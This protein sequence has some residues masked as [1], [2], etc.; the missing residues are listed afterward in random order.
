M[1]KADLKKYDLDIS[2]RIARLSD[3]KRA[4]LEARLQEI[5]SKRDIRI[6]KRHGDQETAPLSFAQERLWFLSQLEPES[7]FYNE[8]GAIE[9]IGK[10]NNYALEQSLREIVRR[11]EILRTT[12]VAYEGHP[13]QRIAP[14]SEIEIRYED[15]Q[16]LPAHQQAHAIKQYMSE[17]VKRPFNLNIGPLIRFALIRL[18]GE[19]HILLV[20]LHHIIADE[21]SIRILLNE[22]GAAYGAFCIGQP[23]P[24]SEL[25][26]QYA[27]YACWQ[28]EW[29]KGPIFN[30][31]IAYWT[32]QLKHSPALL[33]LPTDFPR[34]SVSRHVG[35]RYYFEISQETTI[36]L[37]Q[38]AKNH[39]ATLFMV[40][41]ASF[42]IL[43]NRYTHQQ[44]ICIG[45]P[46]ANRARIG[47]QALIGFFANTLVLRTNLSGNPTFSEILRRVRK[48]C[49]DA[50]AHQD[51]PFEKLVEELA[52]VRDMAFNPLFQVMLVFQSSVEERL[53]LPDIKLNEIDVETQSAKFDLTLGIREENGTLKGWFEYNTELFLE[54]TM[55]RWA[56]YY[57]KLL[58]EIVPAVDKP[59]ANISLLPDREW[60]QLVVQ[61]NAT[62]A[63]YLQ[64]QCIHQLIEIQA[65]QQPDAIAV[66]CQ[67]QQLTYDQLNKSANQLAHY[68][69]TQGI[70]PE[71]LAGVFME[72][73][74]EMIIAILAI[75]KAGGTYV[76]ID[77]RYPKEHI[78][79]VMEDAQLQII[80]TQQSLQQL[81]PV[82]MK[83]IYL[84]TQWRMVSAEKSDNPVNII[85]PQNLA[86]VIYTSG[87]TGKPKGVGVT[88][89]NVAHST[90]ARLDYYQTRVSSF[91]LLSSIAFDSSVAGIFGTLCQ[92]SRLVLSTEDAVLDPDTLVQII[93]AYQISHLL[94]VPSL[95]E[96]VLQKISYK[97]GNGLKQIIVAG[98]PCRKSLVEL[99]D[100]HLPQ[101]ELFNEYGPT[102]T[103][104]WS[105]VYQCN[106]ANDHVIPIGRP[107]PNTQIYLLDMQWNP[108]PVGVIGELYIGG[109]GLTRGYLNRADVTAE[110]YIP[111]LFDH[112]GSRLYRT[113]DLARYRDDGNI[114]YIGRTD[115]QV[116][117]RGFRIELGEI[118]NVLR[119]Y[120]KIKDA[121]VLS[122]EDTLGNKRLVAYMV[123]SGLIPSIDEI[124]MH[125]KEYLPDQMIPAAYVF[126]DHFP[127]TPN[128]KVDRKALPIPD[129]DVRFT[130]QYVAPRTYSENIIANIWAEVL[131]VECIGI[132]DNFFALGGHSLLIAQVISRIRQT[133]AIDLPLRT[134]FEKPFVFELALAIDTVRTQDQLFKAIPLERV[135]RT[136]MLPLSYAQERLWFLDQFEPGSASYNLPGAVRLI[137]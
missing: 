6:Q 33:E 60:D 32:E 52:P 39:S 85:S 64:D 59:I 36:C 43:L 37:H 5:G 40:L 72:R 125:L 133:F 61:W 16:H 109:E 56:S 19:Q 113:G 94:T 57:Q 130:I 134:L 95:Y 45:Y 115:H 107:I 9:L 92:G 88:H 41:A 18:T 8:A 129:F 76:P 35:T 128:G 91:L 80:L 49:L 30:R 3:D 66:I 28:R 53:E 4:L 50:Q 112:A 124:R 11:H 10:L 119:Q 70:G 96:E 2:N 121:A 89:G 31:Q 101:V 106:K 86:Y 25:P 1:K 82:Q 46:I 51:L 38:L 58:Q 84:D 87:S 55:V 111:N 54:K 17:E 93:S 71:V 44:D 20:G 48:T 103:T 67:N 23:S 77:P 136:Q 135:P 118:E 75:L 22:L 105:S 110:C 127:L 21:W 29:L 122:R 137:G 131:G 27:D 81:L 74:P 79:H 108:V 69:R 47:L 126:L 42:A 114:E 24:L 123:A 13:R 65:K 7:A 14:E 15:F 78:A 120:P 132:Y 99:H 62:K 12:F 117:I 83:R 68:L 73:C 90:C 104:V 34:S 116:K 97:K 98:E 100:I 102:E 26:I 63:I